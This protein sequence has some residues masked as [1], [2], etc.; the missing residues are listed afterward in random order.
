MHN[1]FPWLCSE[2]WALSVSVIQEMQVNDSYVNINVTLGVFHYIF[3]KKQIFHKLGYL[4]T[5][6]VTHDRYLTADRHVPMK[7]NL[8]PPI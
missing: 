6:L 1:T 5:K 7:L 4:I 2:L 8:K 3:Q